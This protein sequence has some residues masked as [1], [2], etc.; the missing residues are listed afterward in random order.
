MTTPTEYTT[1]QCYGALCE[2][3]A[4]LQQGRCTVEVQSAVVVLFEVT[5]N[6]LR[7]SPPA[8]IDSVLAEA[9]EL[10]R[11]LGEAERATA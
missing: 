10:I 8:H 11:R 3:A 1:I 5:L 2:L 9:A 7:D 4:S 6:A